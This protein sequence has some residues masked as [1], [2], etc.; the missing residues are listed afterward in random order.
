MLEQSDMNPKLIKN[1]YFSTIPLLNR[2][3]TEFDWSCDLGGGVTWITG[4]AFN[5]CRCKIFCI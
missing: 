5:V 3:N 4:H 1:I 2:K